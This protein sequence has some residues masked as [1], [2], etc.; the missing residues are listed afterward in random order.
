[1]SLIKKQTDR[2]LTSLRNQFGNF[3]L[4]FPKDSLVE[5]AFKPRVNIAEDK[6]SYQIDAERPGVKKSDIEV[7]YANNLLT[8]KAE[9]KEGK[10]KKD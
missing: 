4:D 10:E 1:M 9:R 3:S 6:N 8:I 2:S 7:E 5:T